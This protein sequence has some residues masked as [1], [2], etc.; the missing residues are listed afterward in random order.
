LNDLEEN[1][2]SVEELDDAF[3]HA[4]AM[5]QYDE[6]GAVITMSSHERTVACGRVDPEFTAEDLP[7]RVQHLASRLRRDYASGVGIEEVWG[8]INAE[9][10]IIFP[11]SGKME[12][13]ARFYS[14]A[15]REL[16]RITRQVLEAILDEYEQDFHLSALRINRAYC[17]FHK[18]IR[19]AMDTRVVSDTMK[20]AYE[21]RQSGSLPLKHFVGSRRPRRFS[22]NDWNRRACQAT[23]SS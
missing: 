23:L 8:E 13:G 17:Q 14:H 1:G 11:V 16:Q 7:E 18:A 15:N 19:G 5:D 12:N 10:E 2:A 20:R 22:E 6:G 4:E 21:A 9:I 3:A